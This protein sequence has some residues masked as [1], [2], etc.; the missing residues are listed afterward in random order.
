LQPLT[1]TAV[2]GALEP[3]VRTVTFVQAA[4]FIHLRPA[5]GASPLFIRKLKSFGQQIYFRIHGPP[6]IHCSHVQHIHK[7]SH[8]LLRNIPE[9]VTGDSRRLPPARDQTYVQKIH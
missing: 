3:D 9:K 6:P 2:L 1:T 8:D 4:G 7:Q 5:F